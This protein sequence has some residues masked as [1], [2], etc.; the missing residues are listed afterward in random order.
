MAAASILVVEDEPE[1]REYVIEEL[2]DLGYRVFAAANGAL[3]LAMLRE[4]PVDLVLTDILMPQLD[5]AGLYHATRRDPAL[6]QLP[7]LFLTALSS[8]GMLATLPAAE[9]PHILKK[10]VDYDDL[11]AA[12]RARLAPARGG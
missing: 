7:F 8:A 1:L 6:A 4:R 10:P 12:I 9:Q 11:A 5:G 2:E 3:A